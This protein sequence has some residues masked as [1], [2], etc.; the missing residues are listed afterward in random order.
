AGSKLFVSDGQQTDVFLAGA[1]LTKSSTVAIGSTALVALTADVV[2]AAGNDRR[3]RALDYASSASPVELFETD[4]APSAGTVNR[5]LALRIAGGRLY[6]AAGDLGLLTWNI[7]AFTA[8]FPVHSYSSSS[9][10]SV[11]SAGTKLYV[12]PTSGGITEFSQNASGVLTQARHWDSRVSTVND[13]SRDLLIT[14]SGATVTFW[15]LISTIPAPISSVTFAKPVQSAILVGTTVYAVADR[16]LWSADMSAQTPAPLSIALPGTNPSYIARSGSAIAIADVRDDST[17]VLSWFA[18]P[19]FARAPV[20]ASVDGIATTPI[21]LSGALASVFTFRGVSVIDFGAA[22]PATRV[23]PQSSQYLA[24]SLA[25]T[26]STLLEL[27]EGQLLV[28]DARGGTLT[29]QLTLP[30]DAI[31]VH[32]ST[33]Q[34]SDLADIATGDGVA[35]VSYRSQ[36]QTPLAI[37]SANGNEYYKKIAANTDHLYLFDGRNVDIFSTTVN[38][39]HL[40][41]SVRSGGIIDFAVT[42]AAL[43]TLSSS[44]VV[45]SYSTEGVLL[46]QTTLSEGSDS[47]PIAVGSA[48]GAPWVAI[49]KGCLTGGCQRVTIVLDPLSL[50]KTASLSGGAVDVTTSGTNAYA[51]FDLPA[52]IR[53]FAISDA[54]HPSQSASRATEGTRTPVSIAVA[55]GNVLVL[56]DKL[57]QYDSTLTKSGETFNTYT[58]DSSGALSYVDQ[59]IRA[60]GNCGVVSGRTFAPL[61]GLLPLLNGATSYPE[62]AAVK[63]LATQ[64]GRFLLLTDYSIEILS[65]TT[66]TPKQKRRVSN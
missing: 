7:S 66:S 65:T 48:G 34:Q 2:F 13:G 64:P 10:S 26:G 16:K 46:R 15:T 19:D 12:T 53:V 52:E 6:A 44:G 45:S 56:G 43:F 49:S 51:I 20:T 27:T 1:S 40:V 14:T 29:R 33:D 39:L 28:W 31:A 17:T 9:T 3:I 62:P 47:Q 4:L 21:A 42:P 32:A 25:M 58:P 30:A 5:I 8:P 55:A 24:R 35:S 59:R 22:S 41:S 60:D 54:L 63:S 36:S 37:A 38:V 61:L 11:F 18:T 50:V 23:L 57:Y